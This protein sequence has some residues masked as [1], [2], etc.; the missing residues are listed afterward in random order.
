MDCGFKYGETEGL[1]TKIT[2]RRGILRSG[3]LDLIWMVGNKPRERGG[4]FPGQHSAERG[5]GHGRRRDNSPEFTVFDVP[6]TSDDGTSTKRKRRSS[7]THQDGSRQR[8]SNKGGARLPQ[9][10][11]ELLF[12]TVQHHK[13]TELK[14]EEKRD[15]GDFEITTRSLST[16]L[17]R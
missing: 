12:T 14:F 7:R 15:L 11:G 4:G 1:F 5:G 8:K 16:N 17:Q 9:A 2:N 3:P 6:G 13:P 10:D